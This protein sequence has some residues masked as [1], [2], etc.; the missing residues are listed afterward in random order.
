MMKIIVDR[1]LHDLDFLR[2]HTVGWEK[3]LEE[4]LPSIRRTVEAITG[5][6]AADVES[7]HCSTGA[8]N[9]RSSA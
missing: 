5:I 7:W 4:R 1:G 6:A 8:R 2:R 9:N 3:L